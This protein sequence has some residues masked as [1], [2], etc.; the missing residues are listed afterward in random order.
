VAVDA[1]ENAYIGGFTSSTDFP[2][3]VGAFQT[4]S[5]GGIDGFVAKL[6]S[7]GS[8]FLYVTYLGGHR[9]D[10]VQGVAIDSS[11]TRT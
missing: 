1:S 5:G 4:A 8:A 3:T 2:A 6:N 11:G 7:T 10:Y 9:Q